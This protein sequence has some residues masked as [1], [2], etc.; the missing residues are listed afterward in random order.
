M[1]RMLIALIMS[2][3]VLALHGCGGGDDRVSTTVTI[4]SST[5]NGDIVFNANTGVFTITENDVSLFAGEDPTAPR[6]FRAFLDFPLDAVPLGAA[7]QSA[8][9]DIVIRSITVVPPG[10]SIPILVE[11]LPYT[12]GALVTG[13]FDRAS[14][15]PVAI[16]TTILS[17]DI[18]PPGTP[19]GAIRSVPIDVTPLMAEAQ[20]LGLDF[21]VRIRQD[22]GPAPGLIEI[23]NDLEI[24]LLFVTFF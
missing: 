1:K 8:T 23:D 4:D 9:L 12:P 3:A 21:Q 14:F 11:L 19:A 18:N 24:P 7:I 17:S 22:G 15:F 5:A 13:D 10:T 6:E 2:M 16:R 20:R